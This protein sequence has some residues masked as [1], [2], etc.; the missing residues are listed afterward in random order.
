MKT[1]LDGRL[2]DY[3]ITPVWLNLLFTHTDDQ[4]PPFEEHKL[5]LVRTHR[6]IATFEI[7][8]EYNYLGQLPWGGAAY[9]FLFSQTLKLEPLTWTPSWNVP[10]HKGG[11]CADKETRVFALGSRKPPKKKIVVAES[12]TLA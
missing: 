8:D 1:P 6:S 5:L 12:A 11:Y 9:C 3:W 10:N 7:G 4:P 2:V